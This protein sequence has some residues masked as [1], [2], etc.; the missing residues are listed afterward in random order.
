MNHSVRSDARSA[1]NS[2]TLR[3]L[4]RGGYLAT[5]VVHAL[6]G[7]LALSIASTGEGDSDQS[8]A[9]ATVASEPFGAVVL[10][11]LAGLLLALGLFHLISGFT[12]SASSITSKWGRRFSHWGQ[13][14]GFIATGGVA[15]AVALGD[16]SDGDSSAEDASRGLLDAPGG[17][18]LLAI[19][20]IGLVIGGVVFAI[21]GLARSFAKQ[22]R[23]PG[24]TLGT[25]VTALGVA[26]YAAKGT[27]VAV[28][29]G[30][31]TLAA[32]RNDPESAG[33]LDAAIQTLYD[34]PAGPVIVAAIGVGF[35]AYGVFCG[36]R[37]RYAKL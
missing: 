14:A 4:A 32:V 19:V 22:M 31:V 26:G 15:I 37:A 17:P 5:G 18:L 25:A 23:I 3:V 1:E 20:G 24:G 28:I 36:F 34:M 2:K 7:G 10:W 9:L 27:S 11:V 13:G 8:S 35:I 30:L 29:G 16:R 21:M 12:Q 6:V 33:A